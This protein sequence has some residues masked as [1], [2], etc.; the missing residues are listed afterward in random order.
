MTTV[1]RS[2]PPGAP[3]FAVYED[4]E[5]QEPP[6][7][8]VAYEGDTSFNSEISLGGV[9]EPLPSIEH[10]H[11]HH[12]QDLENEPSPYRTSYTSRPSIL[13]NG[14][15]RRVSALT[16]A[17]FISSLPSE[18][19]ISSKPG[20]PASHAI[21]SNYTP[22]KE[23]PPFRNPSSIRRMM[24]SSP[25]P[26]QVFESPRSRLK[27]QYKLETPSRSGRSET[28]LSATGSRRSESRRG[29]QGLVQESPRPTPTL[30][31]FPL[32]LLHVTILPL[33]F[34]YPQ[35]IM[36]KVMPEWL[37][38]NYKLL[39]EKLKDIVLMRRGLLIPHPRE[40]YDV[41][42]ERILESLELKTPR[43]L[44][45]GHFIGPE[46]DAD[47][48]EEDEED[49]NASVT[50]DGTGRGS[51]MSGGTITVDDDAELK[52]PTPDVDD[53]SICTDC[54]RQV[55][56]PGKGVGMGKKR[57]DLKI[58]AANGLMRSGAWSAAWSEM[59]RCDVEITP[60]I[61]DDLRKTLDKKLEE[62][63]EAQERRRWYDAEVQRRVDEEAARL[64]KLEEE[65]AA[66]KARM[67]AEVAQQ[68]KAD[69]EA[70]ERQ[71]IEDAWNEKLDEAKESI[72][73]EFEAQA[74]AEASNVAERLRALEE[75][76]KKERQHHSDPPQPQ[77]SPELR[78]P[79]YTPRAQSRGRPRSSS[80]RPPMDDIPL[81]TLL[82]N[83]AVLLARD[84]RN[85]AIIIL[86][87]FVVFLAMHMH[88]QAIF[89][90]TPSSLPDLPPVDHLLN[91]T[92][93]V[94]TTTATMTATSISTTT[95][96]QIEPYAESSSETQTSPPASPSV[97][98][99]LESPTSSEEA[100]ATYF[101]VDDTPAV[102]SVEGDETHTS[103]SLTPTTSPSSSLSSESESSSP[104]VDESSASAPP[105]ETPSNPPIAEV[106]LSELE[107]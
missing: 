105:E 44:K 3:P 17:S 83:Y 92:P 25:E 106:Y 42:E 7:P 100:T 66:E 77:L 53:A 93:V 67:E 37:L 69:N 61:P 98:G 82:K 19:S 89:Q 45:C 22:R 73:L 62:E 79:E 90:S 47:D 72:R 20:P 18:L 32:V 28:P 26:S 64:K 75:D 8:S 80:R 33:Q 27:G 10:D 54:H 94:I 12:E 63:R 1:H 102:V 52:Y 88:P 16:N 57:W 13:S 15:S 23:R 11:N 36:M 104:F 46:A 81:G 101:E 29:A 38:E 65:Q 6:S 84:Q 58:Y 76:L 59:E 48:S 9:D 43:L 24:M 50:D 39:E 96:T 86:S 97:G 107:D 5:D 55:K 35:E 21:E 51:R 2:P 71:R 78:V 68:Q 85:I 30:Q 99:E 4:P 40:E 49:E 41:L 74:L 34:P 87:V 56:K 14:Q 31:H 70:T 95:I 60:W 91:S 103:E